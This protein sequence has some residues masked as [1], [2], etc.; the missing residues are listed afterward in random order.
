MEYQRVGRLD[1]VP[2]SG[3]A[4]GAAGGAGSARGATAQ[5]LKLWAAH[6]P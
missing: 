1:V 2:S 5:F 3:L 4:A 6:A